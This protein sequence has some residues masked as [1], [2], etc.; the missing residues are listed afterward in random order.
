MADYKLIGKNYTPP[1]L[2][3]KVT[4]RAKYAEDFRAEGMLFIKLL[5]SPMPRARV[6]SVDTSKALA[7]EGVEA[8]LTADDLPE[9]QPIREA[10]L[11]NEPLYEG[12]P[13]LAV[14]AVDET[15]AAEAV[16]RIEVD[17]QPLPFV[18]DPLESL[19]PG[20]PNARDEGNVF[21]SQAGEFKTIKWTEEDFRELEQDRLPMGEALLDWQ[22]G[23]LEAGFAEADLVLDETI[24]HQSLTHHPLEPRSAMAYWQNGKLY[25]H[26]STQS[27]ARSVGRMARTLEIEPSDLVFVAEY[28]GGGFGSKIGGTV[29]LPIAALLAKKT[30][31]P[32][33][34]RV[35]RAEENYF[36]RARSGFQARVKMGF[37]A[38][39]RI[40]AI[41]FYVVQDNGPFSGES[42]YYIAGEM[43]SLTY[44]PL[45]MRFRGVPL[46]TNT[47]PRAAQ[48]APGG[49]QATAMLEPVVDRAAR[50]LG[51][52]RLAIRR[53]NAPD[54]DSKY[55][56]QQSALT[57]AFVREAIDKGAELFEW[58]EQKE[59]SGRRRGTKSMGVGVVVSPFY[60]GSSGWDGL[61]LIRPDGK[62]YI[63]QGIGNLGTHS[64][65]DTARAAAEVLDMPWEQCEVVWGSTARHLPHSSSQSGSQTTLAHSRA[66]YVAALDAKAKLQEIAARDLGGS[67][68]DYEVGNG[69]VYARANRGR[70]MSFARAAQRAIELGGKFSGHEVS[71][72]L[73]EMTVASATA[74]AGEGLVAA[75]K[76]T[77]P[78]EGSTISFV[79]GFARVAVDVETGHVD[80]LDYR[81]VADCGTV[82][83]PRSLGGQL[84]G[85]AVQGFGVAR[86]QKWVYDPQWGVPFSKGLHN[87]KPPTILDVPL[88]MQWAAAEL[89]DPSNPIGSK[90]IGEAPMP[91]G[92]AAVACAIQDAL[93]EVAFNRTPITADMIL[94]ALEKRPQP[95]TAL[96]AHV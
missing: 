95:Y 87:A 31:R 59:L 84:F 67:S 65:S 43:A 17:L 18:I 27:T 4:G 58:E 82:M 40:T 54:G 69:Q 41:D 35:T 28:C 77:L 91:A 37:R 33:M 19:R 6:R 57:S 30:S 52:D 62:L 96:T 73:N 32:V 12:A 53:L 47:P 89:P 74:L 66:N 13:I 63:H 23:D 16:E 88:E 49:V 70:R 14:A 25:L 20:G 50:Q 24:V 2:V 11:T 55:G 94:A 48:R 10:A 86:S 29:N 44:T 21:D 61:L 3:A 26:G 83:N 92:A 42:D 60:A 80:L 68:G 5:V 1:D 45:A 56:V 78:R 46:F 76:D 8:V 85:G 22:H 9:G 75:A 51:V 90:G 72:D 36:G 34:L 71:E 15:T 81:C 64:I 79:I 38:D 7:M 39:G 93:G